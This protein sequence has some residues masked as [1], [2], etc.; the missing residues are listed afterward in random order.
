MK[1]AATV[2]LAF[3]AFV[4]IFGQGSPCPTGYVSFTVDPMTPVCIKFYTEEKGSWDHMRA[5]CQAEGADLAELKGDLHHQV[6]QYLTGYREFNERAYWIGGTDAG[7]EGTWVWVSD[8]SAMEMG[9]PHWYPC[10]GGEPNDGTLANY[11]CIHTPDFYFH[12]CYN[13]DDIYAICQI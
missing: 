11:A 9:V 4:A 13:H 10:D 12:S 5:L 2:A 3:A 8:G 7:H 1:R 6:V